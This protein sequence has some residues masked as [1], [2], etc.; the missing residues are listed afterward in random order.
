M[1]ETSKN[2]VPPWTV[3]S[4]GGGS[5]PPGTAGRPAG[6]GA[7]PADS[8]TPRA[9]LLGML[10]WV[11]YVSLTT[12]RRSGQPVPT[13]VWIAPDGNHHL[14][15]WTGAES[16]KVKRLRHTSRV[17]VAPCDRQGRLIGEHVEA[18]ARVMTPNEM[19]RVKAAMAAKYGM[20]FR[21]SAA[22][23]AL[24]RVVGIRRAGQVGLEI[25]LD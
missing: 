19:P 17:T 9:I 4:G 16:G 15:A 1:S 20:Q 2:P 7:V 5:G 23:A 10:A 6:G 24:G 8:A 13:P 25:T 18:R 3:P 11:S 21:V 12:F 22:V 14:V